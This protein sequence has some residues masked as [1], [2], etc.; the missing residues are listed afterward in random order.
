MIL[1]IDEEFR[2]KI[3]PLTDDEFRQ[4]EEN[5]VSDGEVYEPIAVWN[6]TIVDGHN[7]WKIIQAHPEIPYKVKEMDFSDKWAAFDWMYKKQLGRRNLS[8]EQKTYLLGKLY[9]AR[10]QTRGGTGANQYNVQNR[11][12]GDSAKGRTAIQIAKEQGV[13]QK[14]VERAEHFAKGVDAIR[15][16]SNEAADKILSGKAETT[17][18]TEV[19]GIR[20]A[21]PENV[22]EFAEAVVEGRRKE[23][24]KAVRDRYA[25][26]RKISAVMGMGANK[27]TFDDVLLMLNSIEDDFIAKVERTFEQ[28]KNLLKND[29][30]WPDALEG[31][32]DSVINDI[33]E[34]KRRILK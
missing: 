26:I 14:T 7:R 30:R 6:G 13:G 5:I 10:K 8:R 25:Q 12:N 19:A 34:L 33:N 29:D 18:M 20:N 24:F 27:A 17:S 21:S 9:E 23:D 2:N 16:V 15:E 22:K 32:F 3:P 28:E 1:K 31:Y 4:L 11:Q